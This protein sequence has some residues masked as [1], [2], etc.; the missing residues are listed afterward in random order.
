M[1]NN[2]N[3]EVFNISKNKFPTDSETAIIAQG[4]FTKSHLK[5]IHLHECEINDNIGSIIFQGLR[6]CV[7]IKYIDLSKNYLSS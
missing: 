1:E 6:C 4:A 7:F 2:K 5:E 3:L